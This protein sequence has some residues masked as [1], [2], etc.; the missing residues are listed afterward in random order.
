MTKRKMQIMS[1][2]GDYTT[3]LMPETDAQY[4]LTSDGDNV[5]NKI[6]VNT[7]Q[8]NNLKSSVS[9]G[10]SVVA[11]AITDKGVPTVATATFQQ[12]ATNIDSIKLGSGN[13]TADKVL[14][15]FTFTNS[16]GIEQVGTM[17]NIGNIGVKTLS[18]QNSQYQIPNGY[19]DGSGIIK[20]AF[21]EQ[22]AINQNITSQNG[23][24]SIP[25][26]FYPNA[27]TVKAIF[28]NLIAS[29]VKK[30]IN[31]GGVVGNLEDRKYATGTT[32]IM[33][34]LYT[35]KVYNSSQTINLF[36]LNISVSFTPTIIFSWYNLGSTSE[37]YFSI[38][39]KKGV[40]DSS[41][42]LLLSGCS[43]PPSVSS[44]SLYLFE[45]NSSFSMDSS[46]AKIPVNIVSVQYS[47][48]A[49]G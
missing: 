40:A 1:P 43:K 7:Q 12:M 4:V 46:G 37:Q 19:H 2:D 3:Q 32:S 5:E 9:S 31:I 34:N 36:R 22:S 33:N 42:D 48:V 27:G 15:P 23:S 14:N 38:A 18:T 6:T 44:S 16:T 20:V 24:V 25:S 26:G 39:L 30:G 21:Q 17:P 8:I 13:A 49:F 35:A 11:T 47:W 10:K 29:N 41:K 28:S 45:N